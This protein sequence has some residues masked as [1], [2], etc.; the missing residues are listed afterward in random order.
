M[1]FFSTA[2]LLCIH[3]F[4]QAQFTDLTSSYNFELMGTSGQSGC[5]VSFYDYDKDGWMI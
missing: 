3:L 1:K 4:T 5:G 2:L